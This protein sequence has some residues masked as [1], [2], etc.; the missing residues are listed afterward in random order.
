MTFEE[1]IGNLNSV[2]LSM[3]AFLLISTAYLPLTT[4]RREVRGEV[5]REHAEEAFV[6]AQDTRQFSHS[7][8]HPYRR[9]QRVEPC[10]MLTLRASIYWAAVHKAQPI[11]GGGRGR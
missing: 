7:G 4:A 1:L 5:H 10:W 11:G 3:A 8:V 9:A 6:G 2:A